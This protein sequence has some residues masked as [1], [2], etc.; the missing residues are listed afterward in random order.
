MKRFLIYVVI[1]NCLGNTFAWAADTHT[2]SLTGHEITN[3]NH[4]ADEQDGQ[5][6]DRY[7]DHYCCHGAAHLIGLGSASSIIIH[8]FMSENRFVHFPESLVSFIP[9]PPRRPPIHS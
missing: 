6:D 4:D 9:P 5:Q 7:H 1:I 3:T 2:E 8:P